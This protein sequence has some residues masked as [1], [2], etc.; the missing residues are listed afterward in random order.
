M[1]NF[2]E[3]STIVTQELTAQAMGSGSLAVFATPA[4]AALMEKAACLVMDGG[5]DEGIASVGVE[6]SLEHLAASPVGME[7]RATARLLESDGRR[8]TFE[9][10]AHDKQGLVGRARCK[11]P[12]FV[13]SSGCDIPP[14]SKW[15]NID[16]FFKAVD[17]F[18]GR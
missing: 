4:L 3:C 12:N 17:E 16:A 2:A 18:Y 5:L 10:E 11:Y 13:I 6:M 14:A 1:E 8:F 15:E 9:I 7:V